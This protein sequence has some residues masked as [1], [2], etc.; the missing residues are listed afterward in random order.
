[1][2]EKDGQPLRFELLTRAT[3]KPR[4]QAAVYLQADLAAAG[5]QLDIISLERGAY[6]E[7]LFAGDFD[8][9][10][11]GWTASM[12]V[13]PAP[14]WHSKPDARFNFI[15][16]ANPAVD[17]AIARGQAAE[18]AERAAAHRDMQRLIHQDQPYL[19]LY[20]ADEIVAVHSRF[21]DVRIDLS[22]PWRDLHRWHVAPDEE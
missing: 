6:F 11:G 19:F 9:V 2:R 10:L 1:V 12:Y 20:W 5:V 7:R 18:G 14:L 8:A 4:A 21:E 15:G 22:A 17:A 3:T 13:D 16:Y